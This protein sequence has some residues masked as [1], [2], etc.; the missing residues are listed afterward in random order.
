MCT[1]A[2]DMVVQPYSVMEEVPF[3]SSLFF[4]FPF[5]FLYLVFYSSLQKKYFRV[6]VYNFS[7]F[8]APKDLQLTT[9]CA[10]RSTSSTPEIWKTG[11]SYISVI[12]SLSKTYK[13][14]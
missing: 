4:S 2:N 5:F 10:V 1:A 13:L 11:I 9:D 8:L 12:H 14:S 3:L 6:T 7:T